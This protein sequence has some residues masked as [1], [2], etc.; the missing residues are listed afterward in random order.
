[1]MNRRIALQ[2][3]VGVTL[4]ASALSF[5]SA[6]ASLA[7]IH[8]KNA[9]HFAMVID[10]RRCNGCQACVISCGNENNNVPDQHRTTVYR[11]EAQGPHGPLVLNLPLMCNHCSDPVCTAHC[12]TGATYK[13]EE[14]G[15]VVIDSTKCIA[16]GQCVKDCPYPNVRFLNKRT[17]KVDKCNSCIH[18]TSQ[19]LLPMCVE[20]C[21]GGARYFGDVNDPTSEVAQLLAKENAVVLNEAHHTHPN[22]FYI[23]LTPE[24]SQATYNLKFEQNW[25]R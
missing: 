2:K 4:S 5:V 18:R 21:T 16:C 24:E 25:Q 6:K 7:E 8:K 12:P 15:T 19:G 17:H 1:M 9:P 3:M 10:L 13:R 14:D 11:A 23:A 22:V 20:T